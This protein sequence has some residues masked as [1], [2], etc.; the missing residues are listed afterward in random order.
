MGVSDDKNFSLSTPT[1]PCSKL[2]SSVEAK[3]NHQTSPNLANQ[4]KF[5][6]KKNFMSPTISAS[7]KAVAHRKKV[8]AERNGSEATEPTCARLLHRRSSS[9]DLKQG[10]VDMGAAVYSSTDSLTSRVKELC[11][12]EVGEDGDR[13]KPYDPVFNYCSPRPKF[14]LYKPDRRSE[15]LQRY[16]MVE[17]TSS[18]SETGSENEESLLKPTE[19]VTENAGNLA[20]HDDDCK[21]EETVAQPDVD[22]DEKSVELLEEEVHERAEEEVPE[23]EAKHQSES[24]QPECGSPKLKNKASET[25][26]E[27]LGTELDG[28]SEFQPMDNEE[29]DDGVSRDDPRLAIARSLADQFLPQPL[30]RLSGPLSVYETRKELFPRH[31]LLTLTVNHLLMRSKIRQLHDTVV[32]KNPY[33]FV[34]FY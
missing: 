27:A 29:E 6:S 2:T 13:S 9:F 3:E 23:I 5:S 20:D 26:S 33:I 34:V 8:L 28:E 19:Q 10:S 18:E 15:I 1:K 17:S 14:L 21:A 24:S 7:S 16:E 11:G 12:V 32:P 30:P 31:L 22:V 4:K 25:Y